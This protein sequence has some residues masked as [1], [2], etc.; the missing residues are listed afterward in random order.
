MLFLLVDGLTV[1]F[2]LVDGFTVLFLLVDGLTVLFLLV[3]GL[4]VLFSLTKIWRRFEKIIHPASPNR[5]LAKP[6]EVFS[7]NFARFWQI[8]RMK[9]TYKLHYFLLAMIF[10]EK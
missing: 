2:L 6:D 9:M 4:T 7:E 3:D 10:R 1:L 5:H 8:C